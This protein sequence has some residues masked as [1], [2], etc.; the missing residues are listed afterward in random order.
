MVAI[1]TGAGTGLERGSGSVLGGS[2]LLGSASQGRGGDNVLVN[3]ANGNLL[4]SRQDEYLVGRGPDVAIGR[5]FNSQATADD[6]NNDKWRQSTDRRVTTV[7]GTTVRRVSADGSETIYTWD[8][9]RSAYVSKEGAGAYDQIVKSGSQWIWTDGD[10]QRVE[11]Y[12]ELNGGRIVWEGDTDLNAI[13]YTY[14]GDKLD[15]ATTADGAWVQYSWSGYNITKVTTGYTDLATGLSKTLSRVWYE[16]SGSQLTKVRTDLTPADN[17][18]PGDADSYWTSYGYDGAGRVNSITQKDGS[19]L[20]VTYDGSGRVATLTQLASSGV[21]RVTTLAYYAGYTTITDA[22]GQVTRL[23]YDAAGNLTRITAPPASSGAAQQVVQFGYNANGDLISTTDASGNSA[24]YTYDGNGN[25]LTATDVLGN[26]VTRTYGS[27]NE[28]LTET[29]TASDASGAAVSVTSRFAYDARNHL[30]YVVS[31]EG[32]VTEF[33]YTAAGEL[34]YKIE[35]PEHSY[36]I[37]AGALSEATMDAWRN[38]LA[39]RSS[40]QITLNT[41]DARGSMT[42]TRSFGIAGAGGAES[43][44]EGARRTYYTYDQAGRLL[45]RSNEGQVA[46]TFVYDGMGRITASTDINGGTTSFVFNDTATTTTVTLASGYVSTSTYNKAGDLVSLTD[47]GSYVASGTAASQCDKLG[48]VRIATDAAGLSRYSAYDKAGRLIADV[49]HYGDMTEYRYDA[50]D[51]IVST[52]RYATRLTAGQL[53][54]LQNP[55]SVFDVGAIRPGASGA[56][57]WSWSVYDKLGQ[58]VASI[59]GDGSVATMAYDK[60]GRL[61]GTTAY[62]VKLT[63]GQIAGFKTTPPLLTDIPAPTAADAITRSFYDRD[64]RLLGRL[65]GEGFLVRNV[66]DKAG[67]KVSEIASYNAVPAGLRAAGSFN[68]LAAS[69]GSSAGDRVVRYV[70]DGQGLLRYVVDGLNQVTAYGYDAAGLRTSTVQYAAAM[71]ATGDYTYDNVKALTASLA[72][73]ADNRTSWSVYDAAGRLAFSIDADG[74]VVGLSYDTSGQVIRSVQY[75]AKYVTG[76]LPSVST[77]NGWS[78]NNA[79]GAADRITRTW[80]TARGEARYVVNAE[81]FVSRTDYSASGKITASILWNNRISVSNA[82][83]IG[84]VDAAT[85]GA[86]DYAAHSYGYHP[87]GMLYTEYDALGV[88]TLYDYTATGKLNARYDAYGTGDQVITAYGYDAAGRVVTEVRAWGTAQASTTSYAYDGLGNRIQATD[89]NGN[90]TNFT[91]D[92]LGQL[93]TQTDALG[94]VSSYEYN[95]FGQAWKATDALGYSSYS[96][97]DRLGRIAQ[98]RDAGNYLTETSYTAFGE[99]A[100]LT[101]RFNQVTGTAAMATPPSVAANGTEDATTSFLYDKL[102]RLLRTT[103]A[104]GFFE[105]YSYDGLGNRLSVT[106]KSST[107][108]AVAG[109]ATTYTHDRLGRVLTETLPKPTYDAA[110][111]LTSS[112]VVNRYEYDAR[113]NRTKVVEADNL[114]N[115]R[116]TT[117]GFDKNDRLIETR[118]DAVSVI[119]DDLVTVSTVT[120]VETIRYDLRGNV[121]EMIDVAG[122]RRLFYYDALNRKTVEIRQTSASEN[123]YSSFTYD[124]AGNVKSNRVY[125][126]SIALPGSVGSTP[127]SPPATGYRETLFNYDALGRTSSSQVLNVVTGSYATGYAAANLTTSYTY[128]GVG[129]LKKVV[130]PNGGETYSWYDALG[131][132]TGQLDAEGYLTSW[133]YDPDN[134]VTEERRYAT[135]YAGAASLGGA[136]GVGTSGA[137]RVTQYG[138]DR[139][140]NRT[141][142]ARLSV[143]AYSVNAGNGALSSVSGTA[144]VQYLYNGLGQVVRKTEASG[145]Q[146]FYGYDGAGRL[147]VETR[148]AFVDFNGQWVSPTTQY[149]YDGLGNLSRTVQSGA[150]NAAARVTTYSYGADGR[151]ASTTDASGF[152]RYY[153]YDV[154]GRVKKESY[155]RA[156]A[157]GGAVTDAIAS[158]YDLAGRKVFQGVAT[159]NGGG[160][161]M[162]DYSQTQY[163][164]YGQVSRNGVNGLWQTENQYD[165]AGRLTATNSGDG[166]WKF[167]GYDRNGNQTVA[168]TSA[169]TNL[170]GQSFLGALSLVGLSTVN[171][172]YT[173]YDKRNLAVQVVEEGRQLSASASDQFVTARGYNAFGEIAS[174]TNALGATLTYTYNTMGKLTKS[175]SPTVSI[176]LEN[177]AQQSVRP[178]EYYYYD[179]S[180]RL[181]GGR[182]ANGNLS[183]RSLLAGTGYGVSQALVVTSFAADGGKIANAYDIHGDTRRITDQIGRVTTQDYDAMSRVTGVSHYG[184]LV[185]NYAYDGLGQRIQ[186][187]NNLYQNPIYGPEE[188][189]WVE[190]PYDPYG[191]YY[192]GGGHWEYYTPIIGYTPEKAL[193]EYDALGR[194]TSQLAFGGDLTTAGYSWN[195]GISTSGIGTFGGWTQVTTY[196]NGKTLVESKDVFNRT[197]AKTDLGGHVWSYSYDI[198]GRLSQVGTG[199][200]YTTYNYLN[201][202]MVGQTIVGTPNPQVNTSWARTVSTY[203]YD[204][205]GQRLTEQTSEEAGYY[206]PG[207]WY[208]EYDP[209][210]GYVTNSYW[211]DESYYTTSATLQNSSVTYDALGRL[212][213]F[214]E[215]GTATMP[216]AN[217]AYEY[218]A[219]GNVRRTTATYR[220]L[221]YQGNVSSYSTT[222]DYWFRYDS[223]GRVVTDKGTL[224]GGQIVRGEAV[225]G[226][227]GGQDILYDLAGQRIAVMRTE[228]SPGYY[229]YEWG[230]YYAGSYYESRENYIYNSAGRIYEIQTSIGGYVS[231]DYDYNTG[232]ATP[233]GTIPAAPA[234]GTVRSRFYYDLVG[235]MTQ[236]NDYEAYGSAIAYSRNVGYN[237][238]GQV[239]Y[240]STSTKKYDGHTYQSY[241][242]YDYG[243]GS[244][245]ALGSVLSVSTINYRDNNNAN[246]PDTMTTNSYTWWDGAVQSQIAHKPNTGQSTTYYTSFYYNGLGQLTSLYV[247]DARARNVTFK[248]NGEGQI[249][250]RDEQDYNW[251][252]GDPHEIWYR[253]NARQLG[254]VGNN[255]TN[256]VSTAQSISERQT[257]SPTT[258]GAFRNG[259]SYG[260]SYAEFANSYDPINSYSQGSS[261]GSYTVR[262]GDTLQG[263]ALSI[264]GDSNLWYRLAEANGLTGASALV[265]GRTLTLP[266]GVVKSSYNAS[267]LKPYNPGEAIGD[268]TPSTPQPQQQKKNKCG[269]FGAIILAVVA[270]AVTVVTAGAA[271]AAAGLATSVGAGITTVVGGGLIGAAGVAGGLAIGAGA[272]AIGSIVSQGIGVATGIQDKFSWKAVGMA[273]IGSLVSGGLNEA[274]GG[275]GII[276]AAARGAAGSAITQG[277]GVATGLQD[278]FSWAGVAAAGVGAAVGYQ[279]GK[280]M[281]VEPISQNNSIGNYLVNFAQ[282]AAST[283]ANAATRSAIEGTSFGDAV[284]A[285]IPD[286]IAQ[287]I[288]DIL[289][290]GVTSTKEQARIEYA[291]S[292]TQRF[293]AEY[294]ITDKDQLAEVRAAYLDAPRISDDYAR[295][296]GR[297]ETVGDYEARREGALSRLAANKRT[298]ATI[299]GRASGYSDAQINEALRSG[300][301]GYD[302]ARYD[303]QIA[304]QNAQN[305]AQPTVDPQTGEILQTVVVIGYR[306]EDLPTDGTRQGAA[307]GVVAVDSAVSI[308]GDKAQ[309]IGEVIDSRP[310]LRIGVTVAGYTADAATWYFGGPAK[311]FISQAV[312]QLQGAA[313]Q[314]VSDAVGNRYDDKGYD[315]TEASAG[316]VGAAT[317]IQLGLSS[318]DIVGTLRSLPSLAKGIAQRLRGA[319]RRAPTIETPVSTPDPTPTTRRMPYARSRPSYARGQVDSVWE[320]AVRRSPDGVV[321]DPNTGEVLTWDRGRNRNGQWD[322]GHLPGK[323][324]KTLHDRYMSGQISREQ[325]LR[326]YHD[327]RN[328]QPEAPGANRSRRYQ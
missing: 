225:Y 236:Q 147:G 157:A 317:L 13:T 118:G 234:T 42:S 95:A 81:G 211:V 269:V 325:F 251:S 63:A 144:I 219:N 71:A 261:G 47:S 67:N 101:R 273:A 191:G 314:Y 109:A 24:S 110:G 73:N 167:F 61:V 241:S 53:A 215:A 195:G 124:A 313:T 7:S 136:P 107:D 17:A 263:I 212:K 89:P 316:A 33:R 262:A 72:S 104:M 258:P 259:A 79:G 92:K 257:V 129:N 66:Y 55:D 86:G 175:E 148:S 202:G 268:V 293:A 288:G 275:G 26:V 135:R 171:A 320:N 91:Y 58:V 295:P 284:V 297:N 204:K 38:G 131:R 272:A 239:T 123:T 100:S 279:A 264:Y 312:G 227:G 238:K 2:G 213:T 59:A 128:D 36:G 231:E 200:L 281:G 145:D 164:S 49:N 138:Y 14:V 32:Y 198:S 199:G 149:L 159:W 252:N 201:T 276:G 60:S 205:L 226:T 151:L 308:V 294:G 12:D 283:I 40:T 98:T 127:P 255:G 87:D 39:D 222:S 217:I 70:Y 253:F 88:L 132:K 178:T 291:E 177:G 187:W 84:Q 37:G 324:Y 64:G 96:W 154:A 117:Y 51:R 274:F 50:N 303:A 83:T 282:G 249:I 15:K 114:S 23:D 247:G 29:R 223:M 309:R 271:L 296:Q 68:D 250:R 256:D 240:E 3:A 260:S 218:D 137:D 82:T 115:R 319:V 158:R 97:Y 119:A 206:S 321:R 52:T 1:F 48:R 35:Y 143:E 307:L 194:V 5:A 122:A 34:Q 10:T 266:S 243:Y 323:D 302:P 203:S 300:G 287:T 141:W 322:M 189:Y 245:Y 290:N 140:G 185:E 31:G 160:F 54:I 174:E 182:D 285:A 146:T 9:T 224:R 318:R 155:T 267:G 265:E 112:T 85:A 90:V 113:G 102:G 328:Y 134:N 197:T 152:S 156:T 278:K 166:V 280:W 169:G 181:I 30:R 254:Y 75:A 65:D 237:N 184:G 105:T 106:A 125:A 80:Y 286:V 57:L 11:K 246:A 304:E 25:V 186:A 310:W 4:I 62:A 45:A 133:G 76:S 69:V 233:P 78:G 172:T 192:G 103:D 180:G 121:K 173:S 326:E 46:E 139:Q 193:T 41:Y 190:D 210:Y 6:D 179:L 94:G 207:Y 228:Y 108:S 99:K 248:M 150:T 161:A 221:D 74:G 176:T 289:F 19:S 21:N 120:P 232:V 244:N 142:E 208:E 163:N 301:R 209:Y 188:S 165:N 183:T 28:L 315:P 327:P 299:A 153:A 170:A 130:D 16:Y 22:T 20:T 277:I 126:G 162:I 306:R 235:H 311:F 168:I 77:M 196:A 93:K 8:A 270:I 298:L 116:T 305:N 220:T 214:A 44:A 56:D 18:L 216:A 242:Y 229:D 292:E 230:Y 111:N 43:A 27:K